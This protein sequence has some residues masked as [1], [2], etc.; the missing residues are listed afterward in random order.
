MMTE[1]TRSDEERWP[2]VEIAY[3]FVMPSQQ[4]LTTRAEAASTRVQAL[5]TFGATITLGMPVL[6]KNLNEFIVFWSAPFIGAIAL[7]VVFMVAGIF[8][9]DFGDLWLISPAKFY[10]T[11]L[12]L[13]PW[14]FKRDMAYFAGR[15]FENNLRLIDRR[16][17]LSRVMSAVLLVE[18]LCFLIWI[19]RGA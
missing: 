15:C 17:S 12:H 13:S 11:S 4:V 6:A 16:A 7:F 5:M 19:A 8:A 9:R 18:V 1:E 3:D 2:A 14:E 10:K